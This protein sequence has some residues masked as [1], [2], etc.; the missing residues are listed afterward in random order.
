M[1][2][3]LEILRKILIETD[4]SVA[5]WN[6]QGTMFSVLDLDLFAAKVLPHYFPR[7]KQENQ[8]SAFQRQLRCYG[9]QQV[10]G[11]AADSHTYA[12]ELFLR[13][14]PD[15]QGLIV[16]NPEPKKKLIRQAAMPVENMMQVGNS[17]PDSA[18]PR[19]VPRAHSLNTFQQPTN[20]HHFGQVERAQSQPTLPVAQH[21]AQPQLPSFNKVFARF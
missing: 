16:R 4:E 13:D 2:K 7:T 15:M 6:V 8:F 21:V 5:C 12:N 14:Y 17:Y 10:V 11:P 1:L 19:A 18:K 9:F 3:F 20:N